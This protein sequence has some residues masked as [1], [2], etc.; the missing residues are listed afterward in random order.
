V[1]LNS[2]HIN[3][4]AFEDKHAWKLKPRYL[5]PFRVLEKKSNLVYKLE[6]PVDWK[7]YPVFHVSKLRKYVDGTEEFGVRGDTR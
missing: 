6:L 1:W 4:P 3:I 2:E 5:G 7:I